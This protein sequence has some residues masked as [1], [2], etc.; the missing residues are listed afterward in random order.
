MNLRPPALISALQLSLR[1]AVSAGL[2]VPTAQFFE[3]EYPINAL[4]AA[5]IVTDLSPSMTRRT[6]LRRLAG[7]LL[8]ATVGALYTYVLPPGPVTIGVSILTAMLLTCVVHLQT[9]AK[10]AGFVCGIVVLAHGA[11]PWSY[12]AYRMIETFIGIAM[13]VL[14]SMV[15]KLLKVEIPDDGAA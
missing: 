5:V 8:G 15:P 7:T 6:A 11:Q 2:A 4:I 10:L 1:A 3:L 12:A 14:V 13:A 9:A